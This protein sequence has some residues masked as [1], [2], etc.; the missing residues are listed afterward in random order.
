MA[1]ILVNSLKRLYD[2]GRITLAQV[3]ERVKTGI[4]TADEFEAITGEAYSEEA[5]ADA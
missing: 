1:R 2:A 3:A 4:I 5:E